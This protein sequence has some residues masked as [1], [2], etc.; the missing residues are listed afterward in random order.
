MAVTLVC[1][2]GTRECIALG[3]GDMDAAS[4]CVLHITHMVFELSFIGSKG[5]PLGLVGT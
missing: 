2:L 4:S 5:C 3:E 1:Y